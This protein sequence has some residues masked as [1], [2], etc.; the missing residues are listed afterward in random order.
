MVVISNSFYTFVKG[1]HSEI[2]F[3]SKLAQFQIDSN[4]KDSTKLQK[5]ESTLK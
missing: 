5:D 1:S 2:Y 4:F 3:K